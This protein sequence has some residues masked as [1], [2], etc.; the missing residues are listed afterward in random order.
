MNAEMPEGKILVCHRYGSSDIQSDT[1]LIVAIQEGIEKALLEAGIENA[2]NTS[3]KNSL[4]T[5]PWGENSEARPVG[6]AATFQQ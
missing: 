6:D 2:A 4:L 1:D 3:L 5:S